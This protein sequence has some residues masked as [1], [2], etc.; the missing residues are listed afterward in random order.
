[1]NFVNQTINIP[2]I[3]DFEFNLTDISI[4]DM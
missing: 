1:M 4:K 2:D 3:V